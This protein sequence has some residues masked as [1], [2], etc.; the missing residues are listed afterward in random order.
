M[1]HDY[2]IKNATKELNKKVT[3][4]IREQSV[5]SKKLRGRVT[6]ITVDDYQEDFDKIFGDF[7]DKKLPRDDLYFKVKGE[8]DRK[9]ASTGK[10]K[11]QNK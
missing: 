11:N 4:A 6:K 9:D 3:G 10:K 2:I 7:A 5:Y 1:S 8:L